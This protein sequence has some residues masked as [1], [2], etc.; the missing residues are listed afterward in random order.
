MSRII[1]QQFTVY[2]F[3]ELSDEAK[4]KAINNYRENFEFD[5]HSDCVLDAMKEDHSHIGNMEISYSGFWSQGDGASF[6]GE[7]D[8]DWLITK[9]GILTKEQGELLRHVDVVF[10]RNDSRYVHAYSCSTS[11]TIEDVA[12]HLEGNDYLWESLIQPLESDLRVLV[13]EYRVEVCNT[14][15]KALEDQYEHLTSI[16]AIGEW[17]N[18]DNEFYE[19][20]R[21]F[22][23]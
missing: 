11:L 6:S 1:Q 19:D 20:G 16:D 23:E 21:S 4:E 3:E 7:L 10:E 18:D 8:S 17:L 9:S 2:T 15:Y 13:E 12:E 5:F 22:Y 14:I